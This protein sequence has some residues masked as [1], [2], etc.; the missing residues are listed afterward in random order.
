ML[1][2]ESYSAITTLGK[3]LL[4]AS[5]RSDDAAGAWIERQSEGARHRH[6]RV[7]RDYGLH[8]REEAPQYFADTQDVVQAAR[9][10]L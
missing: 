8:S 10:G 6:I 7:I 5:W 3:R 9:V 1:D 2:A 4:L